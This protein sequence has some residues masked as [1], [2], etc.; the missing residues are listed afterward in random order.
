MTW[1]EV[2]LIYK[3]TVSCDNFGKQLIAPLLKK[4][5]H[6][7]IIFALLFYYRHYKHSD[8][9]MKIINLTITA[10]SRQCLRAVEVCLGRVVIRA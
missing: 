1:S 7:L 3:Y 6:N 10:D 8:S 4:N 5:N 2:A 9:L